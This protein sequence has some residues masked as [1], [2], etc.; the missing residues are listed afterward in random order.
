MQQQR[1]KAHTATNMVDLINLTACKQNDCQ[2]DKDPHNDCSY[3]TK[4]DYATNL[5][6]VM[7]DK[8]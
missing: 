3:V 5:D 7:T 4:Q 8:L 6:G 1:K 2:H